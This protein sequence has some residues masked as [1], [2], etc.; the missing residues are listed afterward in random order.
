MVVRDPGSVHILPGGRR[1]G[2]E[3]LEQTLRREL[4][5][6]TGW[7][8]NQPQLLGVRHFHQFGPTPAALRP[9]AQVQRLQLTPGERLFL[10]AGLRWEPADQL[11]DE[12]ET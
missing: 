5:E 11:E 7:T 2:G 8:I 1:R 9:L 6:E 10:R 12:T 4:L 3:S